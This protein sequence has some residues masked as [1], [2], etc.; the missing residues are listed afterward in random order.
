MLGDWVLMLQTS[1]YTTCS[2]I[3]I[4]QLGGQH[5]Y[6]VVLLDAQK[7]TGLLCSEISMNNMQAMTEMNGAY[8]STRLMLIRPATITTSMATNEMVCNWILTATKLWDLTL[9]FI[10]LLTTANMFVREI[11][12]SALCRLCFRQVALLKVLCCCTCYV[13][14]MVYVYWHPTE[15]WVLMEECKFK[16]LSTRTLSVVLP[17][18]SIN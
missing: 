1:C 12:L 2:G 11:W 4:H 17:L 16:F 13:S 18:K 5:L 15:Y 10:Y 9:G 7:A 8:C 14:Q 3:T 6:G